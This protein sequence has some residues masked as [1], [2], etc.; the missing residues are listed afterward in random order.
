MFT[1]AEK[2]PMSGS[3]AMKMAALRALGFGRMAPVT[4]QQPGAHTPES[5][6]EAEQAGKRAANAS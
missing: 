2:Q 1:T 6:A 4:S 5:S 3:E